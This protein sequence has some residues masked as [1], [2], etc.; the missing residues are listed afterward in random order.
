MALL[1]R[2]L[3]CIG[4]E[5]SKHVSTVHICEETLHFQRHL[6]GTHGTNTVVRSTS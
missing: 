6:L 5:L 1:C 4:V 2:L 3:L